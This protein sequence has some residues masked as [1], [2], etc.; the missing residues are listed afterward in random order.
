MIAYL[1]E[2]KKE[3]LGKMEAVYHHL[4]FLLD[5]FWALIRNAVL[6]V[7][8]QPQGYWTSLLLRTVGVL[9]EKLAIWTEK[10]DK[11]QPKKCSN[12]TGFATSAEFL[13]SNAQNLSGLFW[14]L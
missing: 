13:S 3:L 10:I 6:S 14:Q 11:Q 9:P 4:S 8:Q 1:I 5:N 12:S 7:H 2:H